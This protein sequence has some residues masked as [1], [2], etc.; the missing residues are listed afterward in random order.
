L[1]EIEREQFKP[2]YV[3]RTFD[4]SVDRL[5]ILLD[6]VRLERDVNKAFKILVRDTGAEAGPQDISSGESELIS[7][8]VE[9]L[10]FL[11]ECDPNKDNLFLVDEPD[12][13]LH[14]DLQDR[15]AEFMVE[16]FKGARI[17]LILATHSTALLA[18]LAS[19][20]ETTVAFMRRKETVLQFKAASNV[21]KAILPIFGAHPLSNVFNQSPVLLIEGEDDERVWQQ[22]VRS[23]NGGVRIFPCVVDG[24]SRF[25][26]FETEVNSIIEAVYDSAVGFSLRDRDLHPEA[27]DDVGHLKRMR[28]SCR[29]TENLMLADQALAL[30]GTDWATLKDKISAWVESNSQHQFH[31]DVAA[32]VDGGFERKSHDLKS[33][34]NILIGLVSNKPWEVLVGQAIAGLAREGGPASDGTLR[35]YL[36]AKVCEHILKLN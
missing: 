33:I 22:V 25:G 18:A 8:G 30:A 9:F 36:G 28:L 15:L 26:E 1:R 7:L 19:R 20:E 29:S 11:K 27:I 24:I 35:D 5:N 17:T 10:A 21:D 3:P 6:R 12:V 2:D 13:H 16:A 14:P 31:A 34:R 23:A 32:F 4:A